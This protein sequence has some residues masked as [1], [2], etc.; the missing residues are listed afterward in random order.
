M[1]PQH[2]GKIRRNW[3]ARYVG[4]PTSCSIIIIFISKLTTALTLVAPLKV[5]IFIWERRRLCC[6]HT[7][8]FMT[9]FCLCME[10]KWGATINFFEPHYL[11]FPIGNSSDLNVSS[12]NVNNA[13]HVDTS[14]LSFRQLQPDQNTS[15]TFKLP[16]VPHKRKTVSTSKGVKP[17]FVC[18]YCLKGYQSDRYYKSHMRTHAIQGMFWCSL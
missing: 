13:L 12:A 8:L 17:K 11:L 5:S 3:F 7:A 6:S 1:L 15:G 4:N 9:Y 16:N 18:T 14:D 10:V 2:H